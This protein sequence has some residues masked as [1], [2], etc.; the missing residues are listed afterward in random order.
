M[1]GEVPDSE[2]RGVS[3]GEYLPGCPS[4]AV[5]FCFCVFVFIWQ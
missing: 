3:S 4:V 1:E 2:S 5:S